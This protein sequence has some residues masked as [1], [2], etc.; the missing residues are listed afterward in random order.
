MRNKR[1]AVILLAL[2][3]VAA[4]AVLATGCGG[5]GGGGGTSGTGGAP[6]AGGTL[7]VS[8]GGDPT[9][10][11]PAIAYENESW[12]IENCL[13]NT[14][15]KYTPSQGADGAKL[16]PDLAAKMPTISADGKTYTFELRKDIKFAPP[17]NRAVTATDVKWSFERMLKAPLAPGI[18]FYDSVAGI[19][20]F[21]AGK[22]A[23]VA[24]F[25]V[26]DPY[27]IQIQLTEPSLSFLNALSMP[28]TY[29]VAKEWVTKWGDKQFPRHPLGTGPFMFVKW[30]PGQE[31]VL[32]K[33]PNYFDKAHIYPDEYDFK[34]Q[35][36]LSTSLLQ[37][38]RG[39]I[40]ILGDGIPPADLVRTKADPQWKKYTVDLPQIAIAYTFFNVHEKPFDN[41][42]VRQ[43]VCYAIDRD[44]LV[45]LLGGQGAPLDQ[46]YPIGMPGH[47]DNTS[48]Y[49]Y[50][51]Q[52]A[53][54]LL[55]QAGFPNGFS[56]TYWAHNVD[57][58]PKIAESIQNDLKNVGIK[59]GIKLMAR[60][61]YWTLVAK[62]SA[63]V[64]IG[65]S[66]WYMDFPDP[67]DWIIPLFSKASAVPGGMDSSFWW[68]PRVESLFAQAGA[69]T[70]AQA[71]INL[72]VQ[73]QNTIME[74][75][76]VAM[77][78]QPLF[79]GMAGPHVGGYFL[80]SVWTQEFPSY[81][82]K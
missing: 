52:K 64:P 19:K 61:T 5:G 47:Q 40:D 66:D 76:P 49:K 48:F 82:R 45:R 13:Y 27:T 80:H 62:P 2:A 53:K 17:V 72:F 54:Q 21:E 18:S 22:A 12:D 23:D 79:N 51:P 29:V 55:T 78:Y 60:D 71:R 32:R 24:G 3:L 75:A 30:T 16:V 11:D 39:Q 63:H 34:F 74:E 50:D 33:N 9:G 26:V 73:M 44:K 77:M 43:A 31:I 41:K 6:K 15:L 38:E 81:W 70:D 25:K 35:S 7:T 68:D 65:F 56:T 1:W 8:F 10:L 58:T 20:E 59:C 36:N 4:L 42:L 28:F 46:I 57:P 14:L 67:S 69:T 37:L